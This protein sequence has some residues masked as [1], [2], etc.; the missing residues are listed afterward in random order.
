MSM[1]VLRYFTIHKVMIN[2]LIGGCLILKLEIRRIA[3][4]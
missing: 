1:Y 3:I 4:P 2:C